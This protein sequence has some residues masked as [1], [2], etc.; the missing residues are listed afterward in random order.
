MQIASW[1]NRTVLSQLSSF[2]YSNFSVC[3]KETNIFAPQTNS[4]VNLTIG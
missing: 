2:E 3:E 4:Y 1:E